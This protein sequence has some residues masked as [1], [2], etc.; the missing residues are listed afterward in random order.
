MEFN[1]L[2]RESINTIRAFAV[3]AVEKAKSGHPGM[4]LGTAPLAYVL[5]K[6]FLRF[7]PKNPHWLNRDRFVLSAGHGSML[8]YS[9]LHLFGYSLSLDEIKNFRQLGSKTP[10][11]P[12]FGLTEGIEVTTGPLGQGVAN[13]VGFAIAGKY[14]E[15]FF[16][17]SEDKIIDYRTFIL[18]GDGC[19]QEG[20]AS[21]ACSLAGNL[22]LDNLILI[23]DNNQITIDGDIS[24][25]SSDDQLAI[26][27]A[28]GWHT[29][30]VKG[31]G[32]N[33]SNIFK[34]LKEA[35][36]LKHKPVF[37]SIQ[38][39]IGYG[40]PNK[41]G[42]EKSHGSPLGKEEIVLVKEKLQLKEKREF[43]INPEVAKNFQQISKQKIQQEKNW[44]Q[45]L[46]NYANKYPKEYSS[47]EQNNNKGRLSKIIQSIYF[48]K[49]SFSTRAASGQVLNAIMPKFPF[50]LG[51]SADLTGSNNTSFENM[52]FFCKEN[53]GGRYI[54]YG[55][56]EH[57][58]GAILNAISISKPLRAY[59]GTFL[60]FADYMRPAIRLAALS[61]YPSIFILSHDSIGLG[62]DG[63]TH[64]PVEHFAA[65]RAIPNLYVFRPADAFE[66]KYAW[67]FALETKFP[68]AILLTRQNLPVLKDNKLVLRGGYVAFGD[69]SFDVVLMA[70]GSEVYL[71]LKAAV[72]LKAKNINAR[73]ISMPCWEIFEDQ[74]EDYKEKV[75]ARKI[76][77]RIAIE[78]GIQQGWEKY[79]GDEG[80][81][82]GMNNFGASA[83]AQNL[84]LHYKITVDEI[85]LQA[86]NMINQD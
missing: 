57:A 83:P 14:L 80:K 35:V 40:S 34:T 23:H 74:T 24:L 9:L 29:L 50:I 55:I 17:K 10:G 30:Q 77:K 1:Q 44:Q 76:K 63:P 13:G 65:L 81:F 86:E 85:V 73:V 12:E 62:E 60:C 78:A 41:A 84:F 18:A 52:E 21:E 3:D 71:A 49:E 39:C 15:S 48:N 75:L 43:F 27:Q 16:N 42:S 7:S 4:P 79:L 51:G 6:H 11:H 38:T 25:S 67:Q 56:R 69:D 72:K 5:W 33:L 59:G 28:K 19:L 61:S 37:L 46:Q 36:S 26:F 68:T 2:D 82:I 70:S 64:Q 58:M 54:N 20:V 32:N 53:F 31:D 8:L 22:G 47:L 66:T 45:R